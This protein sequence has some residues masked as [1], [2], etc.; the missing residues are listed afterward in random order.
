MQTP[1]APNVSNNTRP[2][3]TIIFQPADVEDFN[4]DACVKNR[5]FLEISDSADFMSSTDL[6]LISHIVGR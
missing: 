5:A 3:N 2:D 4:A 1:I 6:N